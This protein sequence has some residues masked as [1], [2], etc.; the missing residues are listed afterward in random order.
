LAVLYQSNQ[1]RILVFKRWSGDEEVLVFASFSNSPFANGY[2]IRADLLSIPNAGWKEIFSSDAAPY[3][4]N[5]IGNAGAVIQS[6]N[7]RIEVN[8]PAN[9][10]VIFVRQ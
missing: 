10:L 7:G 1:D 9:G 8:I 6:N 5:N 4:G 2:V 3:G